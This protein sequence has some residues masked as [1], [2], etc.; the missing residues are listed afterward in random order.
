M[1]LIHSCSAVC[2]R[3]SRRGIL[4]KPLQSFEYLECCAKGGDMT[5]PIY[6]RVS[7]ACAHS[8]WNPETDPHLHRKYSIKDFV[9]GKAECKAELQDP[10]S[11]T[12]PSRTAGL[13]VLFA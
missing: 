2:A 9:E 13:L 7:L 4:S 12:L 3:A 1:G 10:R 8:D 11:W 6:R 5:E